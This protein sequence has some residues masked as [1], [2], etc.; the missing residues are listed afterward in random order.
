MVDDETLSLNVLQ[1]AGKSFDY[2]STVMVGG[3]EYAVF[4]RT[5]TETEAKLRPELVRMRVVVPREWVRYEEA[6][7]ILMLL[8]PGGTAGPQRHRAAGTTMLEPEE[9]RDQGID[10]HRLT[11]AGKHSLYLPKGEEP[12]LLS[13]EGRTA[14][15]VPPG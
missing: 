8:A 3:I 2:D 14:L 6:A 5:E 10:W 12:R 7:D 1:F 11:L 13:H 4:G 9:F 15:G